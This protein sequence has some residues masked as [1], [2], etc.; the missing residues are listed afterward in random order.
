M[1]NSTTVALYEIASGKKLEERYTGTGGTTE[2]SVWDA[3]TAQRKQTLSPIGADGF[4]L[5]SPTSKLVA[6]VDPDGVRVWAIED[7]KVL[8]EHAA[9]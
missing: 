7:G 6:G 3:K 2:G 9:E 4:L 1:A 5:P 8:V